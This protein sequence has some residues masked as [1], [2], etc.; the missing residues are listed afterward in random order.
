MCEVDTYVD[1]ERIASSFHT[2]R[3]PHRCS[4][5]GGAIKPG[6]RYQKYAGKTGG[7]F[8]VEHFCLPCHEAQNE[9]W[10][11][12]SGT[13]LFGELADMVLECVREEP[14][15]IEWVRKHWDVKFDDDG[16]ADDV[17]L[18]AKPSASEVTPA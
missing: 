1:C 10:M 13:M 5:C 15:S 4:E 16:Y 7:E 8:H 17:T 9:F 14:E 12:H 2:A 11:H 6:E 3:K 18:R